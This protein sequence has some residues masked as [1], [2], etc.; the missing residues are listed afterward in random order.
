VSVTVCLLANTI[1]YLEGGGHFWVYLNW[2]LGLRAIGCDV[3]WMEALDSSQ[4]PAE[5]QS[6]IHDLK[7]RL[8]PHALGDSLALCGRDGELP[9]SVAVRNC[10]DFRL[11]VEADL[12]LNM[13]Y[14]KIGRDAVRCFR[15]SVLVDIDPGLTQVWISEKQLCVAPHDLYVTI[16]ETVGQPQAA[17]P[18]CGVRWHY[19]PPPV[20]LTEWPV[21]DA[22]PS[23]PYTTVTHW[24]TEGLRFRGQ[25]HPNGKREGFLP[26]LDL[27]RH[28]STSLELAV[29]LDKYEDDRG[30][31]EGCGWRVRD[32]HSVTSTP[33]D[34][35]RYIRRSRGELSC[36]K[37]SYVFLESAWI[38]D[39][40]LCYLA[41]GKPAIVQHT[42][43][44]RFLP[45][46]EG[47]FRFRSLDEAARSLREAEADY[48]RHSRAARALAEE[49]FDSKKVVTHVLELALS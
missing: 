2:A 11:A 34:Y 39:R 31:L 35:Q 40:T 28:T 15:R 18:D 33:R 45:D 1:D 14:Q 36:A 7:S 8:A 6:R 37:P 9:P 12:L 38:S 24:G 42:G 3:I 16:G 30:T 19:T 41:S 21:T 43:P 10:L 26:F 5:L 22:D 47:L 46:A 49:H 32:G 29:V 4:P 48:D 44:S 17:F 27:P 13:A 23:A 25:D 20:C